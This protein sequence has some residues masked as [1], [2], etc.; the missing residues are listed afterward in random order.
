MGKRKKLGK[1]KKREL[2]FHFQAVKKGGRRFVLA[3]LMSTFPD[4]S[5]RNDHQMS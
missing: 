1:G 3:R 4:R 2:F 5:G